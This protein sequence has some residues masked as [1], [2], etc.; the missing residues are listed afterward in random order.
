MAEPAYDLW[1]HNN[2]EFNTNQFRFGYS[3]LITPMSTFEVDM[4]TG[5][6]TLL[7]QKPVLGGYSADEYVSKRIIAT[8][9]DGRPSLSPLSIGKMYSSTVNGR[10]CCTVTARTESPSTL[11]STPIAL[12]Y[13][14]VGSSS[15]S[16]TS[17]DPAPWGALGTRTE[18]F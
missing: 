11:A 5:Q 16:P 1:G 14:T 2:P 6:T 3:S 10:P 18:S 4:G 12:V 9:A 8:A 15:S 7:K 17:E 13:W